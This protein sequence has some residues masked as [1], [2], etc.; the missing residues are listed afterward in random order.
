MIKKFILTL[1]PVLIVGCAPKSSVQKTYRHENLGIQIA[2]PE[3]WKQMSPEEVDPEEFDSETDKLLLVYFNPQTNEKEALF[4][5][6]ILLKFESEPEYMVE[7]LDEV[8]IFEKITWKNRS[9]HYACIDL[10]GGIRNETFTV[11]I[12][13]TAVAFK[14]VYSE[15]YAEVATNILDKIT[16]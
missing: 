13:N 2:I 8:E 10:V 4:V 9:C 3:N 5:F 12:N 6:S 11:I 7:A 16:F 14:V 15:P 1:I